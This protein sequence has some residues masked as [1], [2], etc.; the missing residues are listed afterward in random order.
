MDRAGTGMVNRICT[1][2]VAC[3]ALWIGGCDRAGA[4]DVPSARRTVELPVSGSNPAPVIALAPGRVATVS[5]ANDRG[6]PWPVA[7]L[8]AGQP[9]QLSYRRIESQP[10]LVLVQSDA[11]VSTNIVAVLDGLSAPIHL[12]I[13]TNDSAP[14]TQV[15]IRVIA[16][17]GDDADIASAPT[18]ASSS[19][20]ALDQPAVES[21]IREYL[22]ANP[23][24]LRE[25]MDPRRQLASKAS[26]H[27][28]ELLAAT[29]VPALGDRSGAVTVVEFFDYRCGY[30]KRSLD[31]VRMALTRADVRV[32]MREYP[33]LGPDSVRAAQAALAAAMQGRY[34]QAHLALMA[35]EGEFDE[36]TID[37]MA[38]DWRLDVE[39]LKADMG[40]EEV[41]SLLEANRALAR[42]LGVTGTP[43]FLVVG[44]EQVEVVPGAVDPNRLGEMIEAVA[45]PADA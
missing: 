12:D 41:D 28:G 4:A 17:T 26:Q 6:Q 23:D 20:Q 32:E 39:R 15:E 22:L 37:A 40:S 7:E 35:H 31:A 27:R 2:F 42:R 38:A 13:R 1:F 14:D 18:P 36:A 25:A 16:D 10:H 5:F 43:A 8:V 3:A 21:V 9:D 44:P 24:V 30:C 11:D 29:G 19:A 45:G 34:E 33:I